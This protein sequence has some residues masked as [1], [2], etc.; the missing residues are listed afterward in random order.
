MGCSF[1][2][3]LVRHNFGLQ[4][5]PRFP[6]ARP[7]F[8]AASQDGLAMAVRACSALIGWPPIMSH[9]PPFRRRY[10]KRLACREIAFAAA[11]SGS[12]NRRFCFAGDF[13]K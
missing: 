11:R 7:F 3:G 6:K 9:H 13:G 8:F 1:L 4:I 12:G 10:V 5:R 2:G